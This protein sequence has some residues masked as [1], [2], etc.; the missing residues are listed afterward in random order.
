[1]VGAPLD[2][3]PDRL[4]ALRRR[5]VRSL[6]SGVALGSIGYIAAVT[7]ATIV[8]RDLSGSPLLSGAP[9]A[10]AVLGAATGAA[11]LSRLMIARGRRFGLT[12]GYAIGA[13]GAL[14]ATV[15]VIGRSFPLLLLG[16]VLIGFGNAANQLSRY[17][18]ADLYPSVRRASAIGL[19][20]WG[21]TI[22]AIVGTEPRW[23]CRYRRRGVRPAV[24]GRDLSAGDGL[25]GGGGRPHVHRPAA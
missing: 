6:F 24:A 13:A 1:M 14:V 8:A 9:G 25:R 23:C 15:A 19:V 11:I 21:S 22:G 18:A 3:A 17:V 7:I 10:T 4:D 12:V 20:V 2:L 16:T 5:T